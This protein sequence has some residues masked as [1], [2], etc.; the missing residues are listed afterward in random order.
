MIII[1][2]AICNSNTFRI[3]NVLSIVLRLGML[4]KNGVLYQS[5]VRLNISIVCH[6]LPTIACYGSSAR[7]TNGIA[8][9]RVSFNLCRA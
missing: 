3:G 8:G 5:T 4:N 7:A 1:S 9:F 6:H 2:N